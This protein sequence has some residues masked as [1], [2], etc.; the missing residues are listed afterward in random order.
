MASNLHLYEG[1]SRA[2]GQS[3]R[4]LADPDRD[5]MIFVYELARA[6]RAPLLDGATPRAAT[7]A[8]A[9]TLQ[10]AMET[11]GLYDEHTVHQR[12]RTG[13]RP[14]LVETEGVIA[15]YGWVAYTAEPIGDLGIAFELDPDEAYIY[16]C[17]TRSHY[18]GRHY[19]PAL[20]QQMLVDLH[21]DGLARAWIATAPGNAASWRGITRAGFIK[22][23][24]AN[25]TCRPITVYGVPGISAEL[26][27][28][29]AW[30][31]HGRPL[32]GTGRAVDSS[33][34]VL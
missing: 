14:Y 6:P 10:Q 5:G 25:V 16:D 8:D 11:S 31:F 22:V 34:T 24:D 33:P 7:L 12:L 23:A 28:H 15:S 26:L 18:R 32:P 3:A 29:A 9:A 19:Y 1:M 20:L 27:E 21:R 4:T 2:T 17:A 13:R 30:S